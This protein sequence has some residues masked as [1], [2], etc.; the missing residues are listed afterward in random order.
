[1][2]FQKGGEEEEK[3][4]EEIEEEE[5]EEEERPQARDVANSSQIASKRRGVD[6]GPPETIANSKQKE[7]C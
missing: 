7:G 3:E 4:K 2:V 1:M 5:E 6:F